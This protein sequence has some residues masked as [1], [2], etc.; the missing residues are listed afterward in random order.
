MSVLLYLA[1]TILGLSVYLRLIH[2]EKII[3]E[4]ELHAA[5]QSQRVAW[6]K[7]KEKRAYEQYLQAIASEEKKKSEY[8]EADLFVL[9][10]KPELK[11]KKALPFSDELYTPLSEDKIA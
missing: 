3:H 7:L 8:R 11:C 10:P 2:E 5:H 6:L 1:L 9:I 4:H